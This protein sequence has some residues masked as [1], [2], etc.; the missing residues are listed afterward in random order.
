M[1]KLNPKSMC[2]GLLAGICL[3]FLA[4][5]ERPCPCGT[6][7]IHFGSY[8]IRRQRTNGRWDTIEVP[9]VLKIDTK[10]GRVWRHSYYVYQEDGYK[11]EG[12]VQIPSRPTK[13]DLSAQH[14]YE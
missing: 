9:V 12:F 4:G 6:Y 1:Q 13:N 11:I 10:R 8:Q 3:M 5:V 7:Q 14:W 2:I